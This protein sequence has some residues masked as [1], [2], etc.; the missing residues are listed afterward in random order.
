MNDRLMHMRAVLLQL[1]QGLCAG[2]RENLLMGISI[3]LGVGAALY[4]GLKTEPSAWTVG[5]GCAGCIALFLALY[6]RY[7][8]YPESVVGFLA[9]VVA[10]GLL[11]MAIG[12]TAAKIKTDWVKAPMLARETR[13]VMVTG[14]IDTLE[15][16]EGKKG[17]LIYLRDLQIDDWPLD[18]TPD[19]V[20][21]TV[22]TESDAVIGAGDRV[23][24]LA[25]LTPLSPP[26]A[27]DAYDFSRHYYFEG[28]G[29]L[30]YALSGVTIMQASDSDLWNLEHIR[31][32]ISTI[33][34][35]A[36]PERQA[37]IVSA[38]MTGERAAIFDEDWQALRA[39]GLAHIIS[40][41]GLHV[42]MVAAP[43]FFLVRLFLVLIP[44]VALRW[45]VKKIAA[46]VALAVC[47][48]YVGL[49]VPSVP[50]TR[51][52]LMTGVGLMAI[53]YDRSPFSLRLVAFSAIVVL[54]FWPESIWSVSFQMSFAAVAALVAAAEA[55]RPFVSRLYREGGWIT[56]GVVFIAGAVLTSTVASFATAV[57]SLYHFQQ[58]ASYS[59][60]ANALV[61]PI[62]GIIIMP[63]MMV[64]YVLMPFGL[65]EWSLHLMGVGVEWLL[66]IARWTENLPGSVITTPAIPQSTMIGVSVAGII[67]I[68]GRARE[69]F[70]ALIPLGIAIM[71]LMTA[72][73]P[74]ALVSGDGEVVAVQDGKQM[75]VSSLRKDKFAVMTWAKR[76]HIAEDQVRAFPKEGRVTLSTGGIVS[77]DAAVCRIE[78]R[79]AKIAFGTRFYELQQDCLWADMIIS[80]SYL[81]RDF[82]G[83][84]PV[85]VFGHYNFQKSGAM[86][87]RFTSPLELKTVGNGIGR[88]PW[89]N[90]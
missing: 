84:R 80:P 9:L 77:C 14:T 53:M 20:R 12:F 66:A 56:R 2:Q 36:V 86:A 55:S 82:C 6:R 19:R 15:E 11:F 64:S 83:G 47:C 37:G 29:A 78:T 51:A 57:Y 4:F 69:K 62:S 87:I 58:V 31:T 52:L 88:R 72:T 30:G 3:F 73:L 35:A 13:P 28:I 17:R 48:V 74:D 18:K 90:F 63:M 50:T 49:V 41:S 34:A 27:P 59:V 32:K 39:S 61:M 1:V 81:P 68:L 54:L 42:V 43:V 24:L 23:R 71:S 67:L 75:Y 22:R 65:A 45:P 46:G 85:Q 16:Q 8:R 44:F 70:V 21:L 10:A 7:S 89:Q 25:K 79:S 76:W 60:L 38:L 33:I 40:I 5:G 26:V